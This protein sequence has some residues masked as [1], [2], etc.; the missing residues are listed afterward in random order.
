MRSTM[1]QPSLWCVL[2]APGTLQ[3]LTMTQRSK[4]G[5][6][7]IE[8][9]SQLKDLVDRIAQAHVTLYIG[10]SGVGVLLLQQQ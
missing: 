4:I 7:N 3:I 8:K 6:V 10:G 5:I 9:D 2:S 1:E